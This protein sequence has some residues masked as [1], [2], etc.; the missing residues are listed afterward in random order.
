MRTDAINR[1]GGSVGR[2]MYYFVVRTV[3]LLFK[4]VLSIKMCCLAHRLL[5]GFIGINILPPVN[6][7][8]FPYKANVPESTR[9][10]TRCFQQWWI[11]V[12]GTL[13]L[14]V[15]GKTV[16]ANGWPPIHGFGHVRA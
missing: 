3:E 4:I 2:R 16:S 10:E 13:D 15:M 12:C 8:L 9:W 1:K 11:E 5:Y 7:H 6:C 14:V